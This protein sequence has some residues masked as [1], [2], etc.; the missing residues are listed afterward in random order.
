MPAA[1]LRETKRIL[2]ASQIIDVGRRRE[3]Q[4]ALNL[5]QAIAEIQT[6]VNDEQAWCDVRRFAAVHRTLLAEVNDEAAELLRSE[7]VMIVGAKHQP[8]NPL[9]V[10]TLLENLFA[11]LQAAQDVEPL[12]LA[13]WM[14]WGLA[15]IHPFLDGNGR[16]ARLWQDLILFRSRFTAAVMRQ[17]DRPEYYVSLGAADEGEFNPLLQIVTRSVSKTLQIYINAQ[18]EVDELQDWARRL[19]GESEARLDETRTLE[20]RRWESQMEGLRDAFERCA[21]QL[22]RSSAGSVE[23]QVRKY[24]II[25]QP[26]W[27]TLRSGGRF[28][29]TWYFHVDFRREIGRAHC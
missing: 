2:Q 25:D 8:P 10:R 6:L 16:I 1:W 22:T 15:R 9:K 13:T 17:Q 29:R 21:V 14:H 26:T 27:E 11:E 28:G 12:W 5:G 3:S 7:K 18:R 23:V 24:E 4:E 20:Y 19:V